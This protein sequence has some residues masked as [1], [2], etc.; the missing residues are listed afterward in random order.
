MVGEGE[1]RRQGRPSLQD[2]AERADS[3]SLLARIWAYACCAPL[4]TTSSPKRDQEERGL[5]TRARAVCY[6]WETVREQRGI[7]N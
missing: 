4:W 6:S 5:L 3:E 2:V 7:A 1:Q